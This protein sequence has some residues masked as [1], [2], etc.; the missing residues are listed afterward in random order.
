MSERI[1]LFNGHG[2]F[3]ADGYGLDKAIR[4][5]LPASVNDLRDTFSAAVGTGY[6]DVHSVGEF[7][8]MLADIGYPPA[9]KSGTCGT[10]G[11]ES[12]KCYAGGHK[13]S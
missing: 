12:W 4:L 10:C 3:S 13:Y 9:Q 5:Y 7:L 6:E 1:K 8:I 11:Q 2:E